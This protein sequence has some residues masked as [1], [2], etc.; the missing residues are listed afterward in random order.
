M[1]LPNAIVNGGKFSDVSQAK[2]VCDATNHCMGFVDFGCKGQR[3]A[4]C[5]SE[6]SLRET[7]LQKAK[8][9]CVHLKGTGRFKILGYLHQCK[10]KIEKYFFFENFKTLLSIFNVF[11]D[12]R[13][14]VKIVS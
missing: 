8:I 7:S 11:K 9:N 10:L 13:L 4:L 5:K 1:L 6:T 14:Q 2:E 3:L 12:P